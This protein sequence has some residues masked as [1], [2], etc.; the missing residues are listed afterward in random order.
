MV[1]D[2]DVSA[3][4]AVRDPSSAVYVVALHYDGVLYL[5][6]PDGGVVSDA[7]V[8]AYEGVGADLAVFSYYGGASYCCA[9]VDD[10]AF[11]YRHVVCYGCCVLDFSMVVGLEVVEYEL[12]CL[13]E[14]LGFSGVFPPTFHSLDL[15]FMALCEEGLDG[16]CDLKFSSPGGLYL[17]DGVE[18]FMVED[19]Y[20]NECP[21]ADGFLGFLDDFIN[22][23]IFVERDYSVSAWVIDFGY[24]AYEV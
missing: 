20:A 16:V 1:E 4:E 2:G 14:V 12:V 11:S 21:F 22:G 10:G 7:R 9:A 23:T 6:V 8:G 17:L 15:Y 24:S 3:Y 19:V 18:D 5:G 13:E